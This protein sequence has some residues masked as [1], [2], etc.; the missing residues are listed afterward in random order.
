MRRIIN[1]KPSIRNFFHEL[2]NKV[3]EGYGDVY[4]HRDSC[5]E[6]LQ[7]LRNLKI[8]YK[9]YLSIEDWCEKKFAYTNL[10]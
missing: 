8:H 2:W 4:T 5:L 3:S 7:C 10:K 1:F 6:C 9:M